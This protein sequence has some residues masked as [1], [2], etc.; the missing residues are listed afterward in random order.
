MDREEFERLC[1]PC[2]AKVLHL[3]ERWLG[4]PSRAEEVAQ[5]TFLRAY[6]ARSS[7]RGQASVSTWLYRIAQRLCWEVARKRAPTALELP[8]FEVVDEAAQQAQ[9]ARLTSLALLSRL[10]QRSR[11]L[12]ILRA[13]LELS[14]AEI[15][16]VLE[17]PINQVG[18]YLQRARAEAT[19]LARQEGI[20]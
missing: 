15:A 13:A 11:S 2:Y 12:L 9:Q 19:S 14:Y 6:R 17:I 16:E 7:Y 5:E 20:L 18:V 8:Q 4:C 3:C 1:L 10:S